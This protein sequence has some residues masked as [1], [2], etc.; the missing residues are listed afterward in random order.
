MKT[1][2][3][4][5]TKKRVILAVL[6]LLVIAALIYTRPMKPKHFCPGL[7]LSKSKEISILY[8][9][10]DPEIVPGFVTITPEDPEFSQFVELF[11]TRFFRRSLRGL[12]P[13]DGIIRRT[14]STES[15]YVA[16]Y[17]DDTLFPDGTVRNGRLFGCDTF[18]NLRLDINYTKDEDTWVFVPC[19]M[20]E[21]HFW[22]AKVLELVKSAS[23][24]H[25]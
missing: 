22:S 19:A 13:F 1:K 6:A 8:T 24:A 14:T 11:E 18:G 17:F 21:Q 3:F 4:Q 7:D 12:L 5:F 16:F 23:A 15:W 2:K 25:S 20:F 10:M 9:P